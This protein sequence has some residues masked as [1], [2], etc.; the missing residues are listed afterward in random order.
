LLGVANAKRPGVLEK[1]IKD[2]ILRECKI[3]LRIKCDL[4]AKKSG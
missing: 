2:G 4:T 3:S 1:E